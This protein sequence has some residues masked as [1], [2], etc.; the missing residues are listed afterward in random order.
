MR[1][2]GISREKAMEWIGRQWSQDKVE[3]LCHFVV[4]NDG[5]QDLDCQI[6]Q[7]IDCVTKL[8]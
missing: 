6:R 4:H 3:S 5:K 1:R 2:D 7:L 8:H